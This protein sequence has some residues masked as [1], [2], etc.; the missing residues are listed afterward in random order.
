MWLRLLEQPEAGRR[1]GYEKEISQGP[2]EAAL[3]N[4]FFSQLLRQRHVGG[5]SGH[6]TIGLPLLMLDEPGLQQ[7]E[8]NGGLE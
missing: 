4:C 8:L 6:G 2:H 3:L 5:V 7:P 1:E